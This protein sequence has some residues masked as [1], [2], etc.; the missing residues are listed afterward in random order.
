MSDTKPSICFVALKAYGLLA[1]RDDIPHI[2]G[3][4]VQQVL[5]A[6]ELVR[7]GFRVSFVT[8]DHGQPDGI[9]HDGIRV[10]AAYDPGAGISGVRFFHPRWTGINKAM[11]RARSD[12]YYQR[13]A[14][15]ETG[16]VALWCRRH[17]R[18]FIFA[19][20]SDS[21]CVR[22]TCDAP[23]LPERILYRIGI[24]RASLIIC[25]TTRQAS[26]LEQHYHR[27]GVV[28]GNCAAD[29]LD[30]RQEVPSPQRPPHVLWIGRQSSKKRFQ[31]LVDVAKLCPEYVF[32]VAGDCSPRVPHDTDI[33]SCA[34][35]HPN[36]RFHGRLTRDDMNT[37]YRQ[38]SVLLNT[39][40]V[41]GYPNTFIEAWSWG[42]PVV[43]T[44]DVDGMLTKGQLGRYAE[45]VDALAKELHS[46]IHNDHLWQ[47]LSHQV[48]S[49]F[50]ETRSV[51]KIIDR[52]EQHVL[53]LAQ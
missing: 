23:S 8:L 37:L 20:A 7:R 44:V 18:P 3:A 43:A 40:E 2:G 36:I 17:K 1:G 15:N 35:N 28:I 4:E 11:A 32:D 31:W 24:G 12:L 6:K 45:T 42:R 34:K 52:F 51:R 22:T 33:E 48:R 29:P 50:L 39:S 14:G 19:V 16:Q 26:L 13:G 25:Q 38:S 21:N 5:I 10:Y 46:C 30:G 47:Q 41:E 53:N 49:Y 9:E 27:Q